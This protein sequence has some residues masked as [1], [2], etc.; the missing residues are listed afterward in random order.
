LVKY[1]I[2][3]GQPNDDQALFCTSC[4]KEFPTQAAPPS[5]PV[6][7]IESIEQQP[8]GSYT[9]ELEP[10][11]H[12]HMRTDV[13][14]KDSGAQ[15][16]LVA[17]LQ[18]LLHKNYTVVDGEGVTKGRIVQK[19]HLTHVTYSFEDTV[20]N[21]LGVVAV[22]NV[23][24]GQGAPRSCWIEDASGNRL[25]NIVYSGTMSFSALGTNESS[26]FD[27]CPSGDGGIRSAFSAVVSGPYAIQL[28]DAT[29][30]LPMVLTTIAAIAAI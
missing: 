6:P 20:S 27:V 16:V 13:Y 5:S 7:T 18:S 11:I 30:P 1:C 8:S 25:A 10:G 22:S 9:A 29:F 23:Q 12:G 3:C 21:T 24:R 4:G 19:T 17:K 15:V 26:I 2:Y 14:L 28:N